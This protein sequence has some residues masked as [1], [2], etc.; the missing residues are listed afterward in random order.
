MRGNHEHCRNKP[1]PCKTL[2]D[3]DPIKIAAV[4]LSTNR[5]ECKTAIIPF[6]RKR[7]SLTI[8]EAIEALK[9]GRKLQQEGLR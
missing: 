2:C 8:L 3:A 5:D 1:E 9:L 6:V 7:F 4:W